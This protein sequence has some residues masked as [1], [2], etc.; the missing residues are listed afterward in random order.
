MISIQKSEK[1]LTLP[2]CYRPISLLDMIGKL[3]EK[4]LLTIWSEVSECG[5]LRDEQLGLR[6][7]R[8][9]SQQLVCLVEDWPGTWQE[10]T[11]RHGFHM[12]GKGPRYW[13]VWWSPAQANSPKFPSVPCQSHL[14]LP[15]WHR[16]Y[17]FP[18]FC[19]VYMLMTCLFLPTTSC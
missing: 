11:N 7:K 17:R 2:L 6:P 14:I 8:S 1:D 19:S 18:P 4:I 13:V 10:V 9:T 3:F 5:L 15:A 12:C 16:V